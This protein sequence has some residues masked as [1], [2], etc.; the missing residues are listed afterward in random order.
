LDIREFS[1]KLA[2]ALLT[3]K[4][5]KISI[6]SL[7]VIRNGHVILDAYFYPF[8]KSIP[9]KLASVT[10]SFTTSLIGIAIDQGKIKLDQSMLSFFPDRTIANMDEQKQK[11]TIKHLVS[12]TNGF[13]SG[14]LSGDE[15]TLIAM[16]S[17]QDWVQAALDREMVREP[18]DA[19]CYD[20]PGM[21]ILSAILQQATGMTELEFAN[22]YL[23]KPLG[24]NEAYWEADPQ[25]Y[26]HGWGDLYL[27]PL[28]AAKFG[29]LWLN[30]GVWDGKQIVS[31]NWVEDSVKAQNFGGMDDYG[32]GWWVSKD[33]YYAFGRGGQNI[34]V[35]PSLNV[36]VVTTAQDLEYDRIFPLLAAALVN[37]EDPLPENP[38]GVAKLESTVAAMTAAPHPWQTGPLPDKAEEISGK[39]YVFESNALQLESLRLKFASNKEA[40][41]YLNLEGRD[42]IWP[43]GLDGEYRVEPNGLALRGYWAD[44]RTFVFEIFEDGL[45]AFQL[46]FDDE[47]VLLKAP[48]MSI[49]GAVKNP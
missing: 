20:S 33:S 23:F 3:I 13:E 40:T 1:E 39:T 5:N 14:C 7:L 41:L 30:K 19:F 11:I 46:Q 2:E 38:A 17:Q 47:G 35:M 6:H 43:I 9:H 49:E 48:G 21:H 8:D 28:D 25:G 45:N 32:Y 31:S 16:R 22:K 24:I 27:K 18:G 34:K 44:P 29:Y 4:V 37:P 42:Q 10:K 36:I 15:P 26:S 12:N